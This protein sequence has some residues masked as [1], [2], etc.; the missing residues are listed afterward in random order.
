MKKKINLIAV[1]PA[2]LASVRLKRKVLINLLGLPMK[3]HVRR[4]VVNSNIFEKVRLEKIT[5]TALIL[6]GPALEE[7]NYPDSA[8]YDAS[9]SHLLRI[10]KT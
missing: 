1:I 6:I 9:R 3:E 8:L 4:R 7:E 5:R 10:K 2:H